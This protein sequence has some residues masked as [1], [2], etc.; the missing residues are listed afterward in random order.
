VHDTHFVVGHFHYVM[1]GGSGFAFFAAM[2][3]WLPKFFGRRYAEKPAIIGWA[4]MFVGFNTMYF[5]MQVL[6]MKGM[7]RRYYDYLPE[8]H[9]LHKWST[10]GS[11][12]IGLGF[13]VLLFMFIKSLRSGPKAPRNPWGSA[14]LEW[15]VPSPAPLGNFLKEPRI[16]RGPYD[17][18]LATPEELEQE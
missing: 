13:L 12:F 11:W 18:H 4:L 9:E 10:I 6:G 17:Y 15:Q 3:Y 2:H 1:F 16:T 14:A 5:T 7:P 8:Y